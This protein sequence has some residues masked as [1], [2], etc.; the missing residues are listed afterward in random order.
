MTTKLAR[1]MKDTGTLDE[2]TLCERI[3]QELR[4]NAIESRSG[5]RE[6]PFGVELLVR[7]AMKHYF[8]KERLLSLIQM[9]STRLPLTFS[10]TPGTNRCSV[11]YELPEK[12]DVF[13]VRSLDLVS[14]ARKHL[15]DREKSLR[16]GGLLSCEATLMVDVEKYREHF[17]LD[18]DLRQLSDELGMEVYPEGIESDDY[19]AIE[20]SKA[21]EITEGLR[22]IQKTGDSS[23][24]LWN[25][26]T[27]T[28]C[29]DFAG[30]DCTEASP[31]PAISGVR[32]LTL[33]PGQRLKL[34]QTLSDEELDTLQ[35]NT[36][37]LHSISET[38][39]TVNSLGSLTNGG[40]KRI[41]LSRLSTAGAPLGGEIRSSLSGRRI[42]T[43]MYAGA[44]VG[45][46]RTELAILDAL[47]P[48]VDG[49]MEIFLFETRPDGWPERTFYFFRD[50]NEPATDGILVPPGY[51][52]VAED[53]LICFRNVEIR[54]ERSSAHDLSWAVARFHFSNGGKS[55]DYRSAGNKGDLLPIA[56]FSEVDEPRLVVNGEKIHIEVR[57]SA[58]VL[59]A[60]G[61]RRM[62][63][64]A[65]LVDSKSPGR[66]FAS[67]VLDKILREI[68]T[69]FTSPVSERRI[70][71]ESLLHHVE[72]ADQSPHVL[73]PEYLLYLNGD[74]IPFN[75][76]FAVG[77]QL[78]I[79]F[80]EDDQ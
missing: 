11:S 56:R 46:L 49:E 79:V 26:S 31:S 69:E 63:E 78:L 70:K 55:G 39:F 47:R 61:A 77:K 73:T 10:E 50:A 9:D 18:L 66:N 2:V 13:L 17:G 65:S 24:L 29:I 60:V 48:S 58:P 62:T 52:F 19:F 5:T 25:S 67:R 75:Q 53:G 27:S 8:P 20:L 54:M 74:L 57:R 7:T 37:G 30:S 68:D 72:A 23:V 15:S 36:G 6:Y 3:L 21:L 76:P 80:R 64:K 35:A 33:L 34:A 38:P 44:K 51:L 12:E 4:L 59:Q 16:S 28:K 40:V 14:A 32:G 41:I 43:L 45:P 1:K 71:K 42:F 22:L